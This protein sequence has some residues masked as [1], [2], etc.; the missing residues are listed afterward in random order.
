M[1]SVE[2]MDKKAQLKMQADAIVS[3]AE[4][5]LRKLNDEELNAE[6]NYC[7]IYNIDA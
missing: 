1:N 2:L 3:G 5:E 7:N 4:K 6:L